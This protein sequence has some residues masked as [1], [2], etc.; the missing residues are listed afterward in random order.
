[1]LRIIF[2]LLVVT[3]NSA[4]CDK[5]GRGA[6][7]PSVPEQVRPYIAKMITKDP[8]G[9]FRVNALASEDIVLAKTPTTMRTR[10]FIV[11]LFED[12]FATVSVLHGG[13]NG[14]L[15]LPNLGL[16]HDT[17]WSFADGEI[18]LKNLG[19]IDLSGD[20]PLFKL[21]PDSE[22]QRDYGSQGDVAL[23]MREEVVN[24]MDPTQSRIK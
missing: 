1:M 15:I 12:R 23:K 7:A 19:V 10:K 16:N 3:F 4:A 24:S 2:S 8:N 17:S 11:F 13:Y 9:A 22:F 21:Q 14:G 20:E 6:S 18:V 5:D